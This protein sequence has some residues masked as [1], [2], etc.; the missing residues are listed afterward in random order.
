M[1]APAK[2]QQAK[3][4]A[5][6]GQFRAR[7]LTF[8]LYFVLDLLLLGCYSLHPLLLYLQLHAQVFHPRTLCLQLRPVGP[9]H[10]VPCACVCVCVRVCACVC[11]CLCVFV[12]LRLCL[13]VFVCLCLCLCVSLCVRACTCAVTATL[14]FRQDQSPVPP[15]KP[16]HIT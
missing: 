13:C 5:K 15:V 8:A 14:K 12:C 9:K 3:G 10:R 11:V 16:T 4:K 2:D 6:K 7:N 1:C